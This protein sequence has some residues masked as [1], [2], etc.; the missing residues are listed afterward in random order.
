MTLILRSLY[1]RRKRQLIASEQRNMPEILV[2][3]TLKKIKQAINTESYLHKGGD[4]REVFSEEI[5]LS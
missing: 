3:N 1:L 4:G 5:M 2:I